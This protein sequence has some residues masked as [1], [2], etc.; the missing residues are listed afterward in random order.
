MLEIKR[1]QTS[2]VNLFQGER[3]KF[4]MISALD[5]EHEYVHTAYELLAR[6]LDTGIP[7]TWPFVNDFLNQFQTGSIIGDIGEILL[8]SVCCHS[9]SFL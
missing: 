6:L 8:L 4:V 9:F 5:F 2:H 3:S 7:K 1:L